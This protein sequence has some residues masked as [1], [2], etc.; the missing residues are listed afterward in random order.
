MFRA[1]MESLTDGLEEGTRG[2]V[3]AIANRQRE[4]L[5]TETANVPASSFAFG[6]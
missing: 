4:M 6:K 5:L 1:Y 3:M 2:T